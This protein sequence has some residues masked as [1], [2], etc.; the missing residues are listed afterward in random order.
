MKNFILVCIFLFQFYC[1]LELCHKV[2]MIR[3]DTIAIK[4]ETELTRKY[5]WSLCEHMYKKK[6]M[7]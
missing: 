4:W 2:N 6:G 1:H 5:C 7:L 3:S